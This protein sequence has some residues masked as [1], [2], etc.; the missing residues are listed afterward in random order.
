MARQANKKR[1]SGNIDLAFEELSEF[2]PSKTTVEG[3]LENKEIAKLIDTFLDN[4]FDHGLILKSENTSAMHET[5]T[6]PILS[7]TSKNLF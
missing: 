6:S 3:K 4:Q 7:S 5:D 1:G 2:I